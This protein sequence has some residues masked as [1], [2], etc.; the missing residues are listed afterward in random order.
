V[1][2][3]VEQSQVRKNW[4]NYITELYDRINRKETLA[5]EPEE[6]EED[7]DEK[8]LYSAKWSGKIHQVNE[9]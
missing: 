2:R 4:E 3:I 7:T 1:N 9:E 8:G 5:V 6:Q